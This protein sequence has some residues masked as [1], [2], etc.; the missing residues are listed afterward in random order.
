M[1]QD[2]EIWDLVRANGFTPAARASRATL[3]GVKAA[4]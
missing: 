2:G 4:A 1:P 3:S